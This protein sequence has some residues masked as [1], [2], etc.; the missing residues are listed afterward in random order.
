MGGDDILVLGQVYGI[1]SDMEA[2]DYLTVVSLEHGDT[3]NDCNYIWPFNITAVAVENRNSI[4]V[5]A[6][7]RRLVKWNGIS[8]FQVEWSKTMELPKYLAYD[9][10]T[11]IF[12][13]GQDGKSAASIATNTGDNERSVVLPFEVLIEPLSLEGNGLLIIGDG[14]AVVL[15]GKLSISGEFRASWIAEGAVASFD[16]SSVFVLSSGKLARLTLK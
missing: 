8:E 1:F 7:Y 9:K 3:S 11:G 10:L 5:S 6:Y 15:G 2:L 14:I 12:V 16:G 4:I 13:V